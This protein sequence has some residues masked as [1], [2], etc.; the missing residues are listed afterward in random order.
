MGR[1]GAGSS[2]H[3][4]NRAASAARAQRKNETF[5]AIS[6]TKLTASQ[7]GGPMGGLVRVS[8][9]IIG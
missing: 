8:R 5:P 6:A 2:Q 3:R 1:E 4:V 9:A 7:A